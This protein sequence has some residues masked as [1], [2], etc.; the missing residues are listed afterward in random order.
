MALLWE[1][2]ECRYRYRF[3]RTG[4]IMSCFGIELF[5]T[6]AHVMCTLQARESK[7]SIDVLARKVGISTPAHLFNACGSGDIDAGSCNGNA[8]GFTV[9]AQ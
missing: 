6:L 7:C 9:W 2:T 5:Q 1:D 4:R 3:G 8:V